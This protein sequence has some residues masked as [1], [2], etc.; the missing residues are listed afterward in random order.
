MP[1]LSQLYDLCSSLSVCQATATQTTH[2]YTHSYA[3]RQFLQPPS[4]GGLVVIHSTNHSDCYHFTSQILTWSYLD[5]YPLV[6]VHIHDEFIVLPHWE[7]RPPTPCPHI[8][9]GEIILILTLTNISQI[10][11]SDVDA[12]QLQ[13]NTLS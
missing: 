9:L 7:S 1:P 10:H 5:G 8:S 3:I 4:E 2:T 6:I 12:Y 13:H 11:Y